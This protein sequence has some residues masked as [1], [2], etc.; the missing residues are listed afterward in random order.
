MKISNPEITVRNAGEVLQ[1][2]LAAVKKGDFELDFAS[3]QKIDSSALAVILS[4]KRA[5]PQGKTLNL[6]NQPA[7]LDSLISAYGVQSLFS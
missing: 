6:A 7:Q 5:L 4:A 3:V 1:Q 2:V